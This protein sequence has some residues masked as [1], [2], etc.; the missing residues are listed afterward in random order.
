MDIKAIIAY[1]TISQL[2]Y[3]I[4]AVSLNNQQS[5][6]FHLVI[7]GLFKAG[8]FL[9]AGSIIHGLADNQDIRTSGG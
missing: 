1:S 6:L 9:A 8:L 4:I 2:A 7:H 5:A 3:L